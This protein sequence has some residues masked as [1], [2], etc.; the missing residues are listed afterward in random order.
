MHQVF[1][2]H[3]DSKHRNST[4]RRKWQR[5]VSGRCFQPVT[6]LYEGAPV[7]PLGGSHGVPTGGGN[8][9]MGH[10]GPRNMG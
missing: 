10:H 6:S 9:Q 2:F 5:T 3:L 1:S 4:P 8:H 7:A